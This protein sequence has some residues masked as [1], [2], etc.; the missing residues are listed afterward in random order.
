MITHLGVGRHAH[1]R[2][3]AHERPEPRGGADRRVLIDVRAMADRG[4]RGDGDGGTDANAVTEREGRTG[5]DPLGRRMANGTVPHGGAGGDTDVYPDTHVLS[6]VAVRIERAMRTDDRPRID[7]RT[8][9]DHGSRPHAHARHHHGAMLEPDAVRQSRLGAYDAK[10][11]YL[12]ADADDRVSADVDTRT[13]AGGDADEGA[14]ADDDVGRDPDIV[15]N[16]SGGVNTR[17]IGSRTR[18]GS[19]GTVRGGRDNRRLHPENANRKVSTRSGCE[20]APT[21]LR[22][23]G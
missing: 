5:Q 17:G 11:A 1:A 22:S 18:T 19:A 4:T 2:R 12:D 20:P 9:A 8:G 13:K 21:E 10:R 7:D 14:L 3:H 15:R 16:E 6:H 23:S